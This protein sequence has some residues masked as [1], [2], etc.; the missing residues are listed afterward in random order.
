MNDGF[1]LNTFETYLLSNF[2]NSYCLKYFRQLLLDAAKPAIF[3]SMSK[4]HKSSIKSI[5]TNQSRHLEL[6]DHTNFNS[7]VFAAFKNLYFKAAGRLTRCNESWAIQ[8]KAIINGSAFLVTNTISSVLQST[9]FFW[10][11]PRNCYYAVSA[12]NRDLFSK[13]LGHAVIDTAIDYCI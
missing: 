11:S 13:P 5:R 10:L 1:E 9:S 6:Y 3:S 7:L 4:G 8:E 2:S 12:S